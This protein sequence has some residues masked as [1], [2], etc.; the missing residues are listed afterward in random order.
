M[1]EVAASFL[2]A[3]KEKIMQTIYD[4]EVA[5]VDYF[6]IDV[7]DGKFVENDTSQIMKEYTEYIKQISTIPVEVH[8]MVEDIENYIKSYLA[9]EPSIII[10]HIEACKNEKQVIEMMA[11]LKENH[12][13]VG[14]C[15]SP[16]TDMNVILEYIPYIHRVLVMTVEPGKGGQKLLPET[17]SKIKDLNRYIYDNGYEVD[18]EVDGGINS[19]TC[20][21]VVEAGASILVAGSYLMHS[22]NYK[23]AIIKLKNKEK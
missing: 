5:G 13:K 10:F 11:L 17:I 23:E 3:N 8:L 7:M 15:V 16:K 21:P 14:L 9:I 20:I 6:H 2:D 22:E 12:C 4:L 18:I 1:V 19:Q